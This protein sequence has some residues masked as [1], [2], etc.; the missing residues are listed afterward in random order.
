[1]PSIEV[2]SRDFETVKE[3]QEWLDAY[4]DSYSPWGYSTQ[5][6]IVSTEN[7]QWRVTGSRWSSSD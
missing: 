1:M 3:A 4:L 2:Q 7:G 5:L 6:A